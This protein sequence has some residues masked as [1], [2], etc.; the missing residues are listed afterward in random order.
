MACVACVTHSVCQ[1]IRVKLWAVLHDPADEEQ[2]QVMTMRMLQPDDYLGI[3]ELILATPALVVHEIDPWSPL[4]P[5]PI[6]FSDAGNA[7]IG[8]GGGGDDGDDGDGGGGGNS[9]RRRSSNRWNTFT[10]V[11]SATQPDVQ[12]TW[13]S[14]CQRL[15]DSDVALRSA[16]PCNICGQ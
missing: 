13:P 8:G 16:W 1:Y 12:Y 10:T 15:I 11:N 3:N 14:P 9:K 5:K 6:Y 4:S 7:D 2:A